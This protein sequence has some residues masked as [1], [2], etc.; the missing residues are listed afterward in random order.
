MSELT[1]VPFTGGNV[2]DI[3]QG[4]RNLAD[5][6]ENGCMEGSVS[7][8]VDV[9]RLAWVTL[10]AYGDIQAGCLGGQGDRYAAM[11]LLQGGAIHI[12]KETV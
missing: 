4:L 9:T 12:L 3:P 6:I 8:M 11:G 5:L 10:N 1:V 7:S 2:Q